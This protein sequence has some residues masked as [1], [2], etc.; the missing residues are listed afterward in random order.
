MKKFLFFAALSLAVLSAIGQSI[1]VTFTGRNQNGDYHSFTG[2]S[3][4][5]QTRGWEQTL[6]YPDTTLILNI[7]QQ[8]IADIDRQMSGLSA[9]VPNPFVG[10]ATATLTLAE[11]ERVSF[12][13]VRINGQ[14]IVAKEL[15]L[16]SGSHQIG[17]SLAETQVAFLVVKTPTQRHVAK[18][19][20]KGTGGV[21]AIRLLGSAEPQPQPKAVAEGDFSMGDMMRYVGLSSDGTSAAVAKAQ[22]A[23]ELITLVFDEEAPTVYLPTVST[24]SASD[25]TT[26]SATSGGNVTDDG[27]AAVTAR[28]VCWSTSHNP[29]VGGSHTSD[30]SGTGSFTSS[31]TGLTANTTYYV[32]AYATNSQGTTYGEERSFTTAEEAVAGAFDANGASNS[33][34]SVSATSQVK[35]SRGNLQYHASTGTWRFA[36]N[37][38]DYIGS[39]NSNISSSYSG[40]ID[41]FGW[42]TSG[43]N[44]GANA[45]QPWSTSTIYSDYYPGGS[46]TNSLTRSY[47]NADWGVYNAISNGGSQ[48]GLWRT[49][50]KDEWNYLIFYRSATYRYVKATVNGVSGMIVFPDSFAMPSGIVVTGQNATGTSFSS[51]SY[52]L[53][54]WQTLESAGCIFLPAAGRRVGTEVDV[55][56][57]GGY[58]WSSTSGYGGHAWFMGFFGNGLNMYN[59]NR[60]YGLSVRLVKD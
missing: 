27:N 26:N 46:Y 42:G 41:L 37:Q 7:T 38:Y 39:N 14:R 6:T 11:S 4:Q 44:S 30:G 13:V 22:Q 34:F 2:V 57:T 5:N 50:T 56:G 3:V 12:E 16:P 29:T 52:S 24:V 35:F 15:D 55:V 8:G 36:E 25:I 21:N 54:Q 60:N 20:N 23:N 9:V 33:L 49:L 51:N 59:D 53:D 43:W 18:L 58:Y 40:W 19:A 1:V 47:A 17:L 48:A 32:R 10:T 31:I 28:G 45:Y